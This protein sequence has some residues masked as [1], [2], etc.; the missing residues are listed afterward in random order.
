MKYII[1]AAVFLFANNIVEKTNATQLGNNV[2][3]FS[4][5]TTAQFTT[6]N[7]AIDRRKNLK[8]FIEDLSKAVSSNDKAAVATMVRFPFVDSWYKEGDQSL[9]CKNKQEFIKKFDLIF[10][11]ELKKAIKGG[12]YYHQATSNENSEAPGPLNQG[13]YMFD[14][15]PSNDDGTGRNIILVFKKVNGKFTITRLGFAS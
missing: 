2:T 3:S 7:Q 13:E 6:P 15:S 12:K 10:I 9:S 11:P 1:L 5:N 8:F 14:A 4:S